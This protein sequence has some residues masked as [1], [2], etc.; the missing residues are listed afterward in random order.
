MQRQYF[1]YDPGKLYTP[2]SRLQ[3]SRISLA[4][5][6]EQKLLLETIEISEAY[7]NGD[8]QELWI[9][10]PT[11]NVFRCSRVPGKVC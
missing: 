11:H 8:L 4:K 7:L 5:A 6:T 1:D 3:I 2:V 9:M 10:E